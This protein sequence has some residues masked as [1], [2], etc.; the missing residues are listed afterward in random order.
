MDAENEVD[1]IKAELLESCSEFREECCSEIETTRLEQHPNIAVLC[2]SDSR[3]PPELIF[4]KTVGEMFIVRVAGNVAV[5]PSVIF[6]LEYAVNHLGVKLLIILGHTDCG[7]VNAAENVDDDVNIVIKDIR[8]SFTLDPDHS[9]S[10]V[11]HQ[12]RML[13]ERSEIIRDALEE[14]TFKL[15]GAY[16]HI[17]DGDVEFL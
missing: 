17:E 14:D 4:K 7:A 5:D 2:C 13:P 8:D 12:L 3:V 11:L 10:N 1:A 16:Y 9:R 15:L 6:S